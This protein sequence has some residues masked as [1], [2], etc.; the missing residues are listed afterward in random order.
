M[1]PN[2][3]IRRL[4]LGEDNCIS[5]NDGVE[6]N[7]EWDAPEYHDTTEAYDGETN[8]ENDKNLISN[9]F[10]V[11]QCLEHE[12]KNGDKV[13]KKELIVTLRG[14]IYFVKFII[15]LEEDDIELGVDAIVEGIDFGDILEIGGLDLPPFSCNMGKSSENK[16]K[17]NGNYKITYSD[18][19]PSLT[20]KKPLTQEEIFRKAIDQDIYERILI[21]QEPR[22]IIETL[23]LS[24]Q[25]KKLLDSVLLD[26]LKLDGEVEINEEEATTEVI[27]NYKA[28]RDKNDLEVFVL[29][30]RIEGKYD[31]HA[32]A[33]TGLNINVLPYGIYAKIGRGVLF[34]IMDPN[35]SIRRLCLGEDNCISLNDG[36]E[37]NG[38][39]DA[40]EYHDTTG[41]GQKKEAKAFTFIPDGNGRDL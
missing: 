7:G 15:N 20:V 11:Q 17:P 37:S 27:R 2:T 26:K 25:H 41:S 8:L 28:I 38:E 34:N 32:L 4:C 21:L 12:V 18:E 30:I 39:W 5:L 6:S 9:E 19:G 24:D 40:P 29:P 31:T 10:A 33:D 1:D 14:E 35:P 23:K 3:S 36:V 22:P 16:K 13:V